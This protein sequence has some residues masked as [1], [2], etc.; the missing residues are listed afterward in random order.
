MQ[1]CLLVACLV[2]A[3]CVALTTRETPVTDAT[4]VKDGAANAVICVPSR[5]MAPDDEN[6]PGPISHRVDDPAQQAE[7]QRRRLRESVKDLARCIEKMSGAGLQIVDG[8]VEES[9]PRVRILIGEPA[10]ALVGPPAKAYPFKQGFRVV[11]SER[12]VALVGESDLA[13]SYSVYEILD[14]LGCRW[15]MPSDMG[16]VIPQRATV[17]LA[18]MD[19]SSGPATTYRALWYCGE[20]YFRR[21]RLGGL[22]VYAGH[23]LGSYLTKEDL[24]AHPEWVAVIN[25]RPSPPTLKWTRPEVAEAIAQK[26]LTSIEAGESRRATA[27]LSPEDQIHFDESEDPRFDAGDTDPMFGKPS[28]TDRL[29]VLCNR[30]ADRVTAEHPDMLFGMLAYVNYTRAPVR[31]KVHPSIV[32]LIA[33][34]TY[35][36]V[37]PL[38]D[39][40]EPN[41]KALREL[42]AGWGRAT[43]DTGT[44]IYLYGWNLSEMTAPNPMITKW[45]VDTQYVLRHGCRF[46]MPETS[47]NFE[48]TMHALYLGPKLAWDPTRKPDQIIDDLHQRFYG[49]AAEQMAAYW[50]FIDRLWVDTPEFSGGPVGY[51][52]RFTPE[53]MTE[54]REL[55]NAGI[56]ATRT[57]QEKARVRMADESLILFEKYMKMRLDF[58]EGRFDRL[59]AEST[60]WI[61][62]THAM[63]ERYRDQHAFSARQYGA[64]G[65][66]GSNDG[67]DYFV[68]WYKRAYDEAAYIAGHYDILTP[69]PIRNWRFHPDPENKGQ[70]LGWHEPPF[71][72][73]EWKAADVCVDSWSHLGVHNYLGRAWYRTNVTVEPGPAGRRTFLW[74]G[75][76]DGTT[77][78]FVNGKPASWRDR[79]GTMSDELTGFCRPVSF[80]I[81]DLLAAGQENSIVI[82]CDR[83]LNEIGSGGLIGPIVIYREPTAPSGTS[84]SGR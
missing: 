71:D 47:S 69:Q 77:R 12:S 43:S 33:P 29:L 1:S 42:I 41:N 37:H 72:D 24:E 46:Y 49:H 28:L 70:D 15:F 45:G 11:V 48:T 63:A 64:G 2:S 57:D 23:A 10:E 74:L 16:E 34:I 27:S 36:R 31:E 59:D 82:R 40:R 81:T 54:A 75:L 79:D 56:K 76:S 84:V 20:D 8:D 50:H 14:R 21:N 25:G 78:V 80:D 17:T 26:I 35:S 62:R 5:V 73:N 60:A 32:P 38:T 7:Y 13:L 61:G 53:R 39:D 30:I 4:L 44:G 9:D 3:S 55:M 67:V 52:K 68:N 66:W 19:F 83:T 22:Y 65:I 58:I 6:F 18:A 51:M